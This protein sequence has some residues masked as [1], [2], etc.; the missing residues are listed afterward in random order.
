MYTP[1]KE[2]APEELTLKRHHRTHALAHF[3]EETTACN[4]RPT[5]R[6]RCAHIGEMNQYRYRYVVC[7]A[8][9]TAVCK[10]QLHHKKENKIQPTTFTATTRAS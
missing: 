6:V 3:V 2:G 8:H 1:K 5:S 7:A 4:L 10:Q 9:T